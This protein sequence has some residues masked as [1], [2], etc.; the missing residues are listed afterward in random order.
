MIRLSKQAVMMVTLLAAVLWLQP[1]P[2]YASK[3]DE[4]K[5]P[6]SDS[7]RTQYL[8][9]KGKV[10]AKSPMKTQS[11]DFHDGLA[12]ISSSTDETFMDRAGKPAMANHFS[13]ADDFSEGLAGVGVRHKMGFID[14]GGA[15]AIAPIFEMVLPFH[16]GLA[17]VK[18]ND[19]CGFVD[20]SGRLVIDALFD[21]AACFS[22]GLAAVDIEGKL[23]YIDK[24]GNWRI[25]PQFDIAQ[26]FSNGIALVTSYSSSPRIKLINTRGDFVR[27]VTETMP[28]ET[29]SRDAYES[30]TGIHGRNSQRF[31]PAQLLE[32]CSFAEGLA[33][34]SIE[35]KYGYVDTSGKFVI[36]PLF[37]RAYPFADGRALICMA[38]KYGYID[39]DGKIAVTAQFYD[40]AAYS[41]GLAAV[42]V[43]KN[44]W[45]YIDKEGKFVVPPKYWKAYPFSE[46]LGRVLRS[47]NCICKPE[48]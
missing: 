2:I 44:K 48:K 12:R 5:P 47:G 1:Q 20:K 14:K 35:H 28:T 23:G 42:A 30:Y 32:D 9:C 15:F 39:K 33:P 17:P 27:E 43:A 7:D 22:E 8:D 24:N 29:F 4:S 10:I 26:G 40:G 11:F 45:G 46:G 6:H 38:G 21:N 13:S 19:K 34:L 31:G 36:Q 25:K 16:E 37:D 41:E 3:A 18:I